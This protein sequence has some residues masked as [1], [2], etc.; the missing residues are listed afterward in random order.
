MTNMKECIN[1]DSINNFKCDICNMGK[2]TRKPHPIFDIDKNSEIQELLHI[3]LCGTIKPELFRSAKYFMII[4]DNFSGIHF[5]FYYR[6]KM[7]CF[8]S[9]KLNRCENLTSKYIKEVHPD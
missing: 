9:L 4:V 5:F 7:K 6:V 3:D 8:D 2:R 1:I